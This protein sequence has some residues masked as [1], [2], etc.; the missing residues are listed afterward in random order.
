MGQGPG[1]AD[2][3]A[4]ATACARFAFAPWLVQIMDNGRQHSSA[5]DV[6]RSS[7]FHFS[8]NA[9]AAGAQD[10][11]VVIKPHTIMR[12]VNVKMGVTIRKSHMINAQHLG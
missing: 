8:A 9:H 4:F 12:I 7:T 2:I 10:A 11:P 6:F 5:P 1:G 3:H